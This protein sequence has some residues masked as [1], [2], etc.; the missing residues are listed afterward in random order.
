MYRTGFL[1]P[2]LQRL[3]TWSPVW[4]GAG[5]LLYFAP[6]FEPSW[7]WLLLPPLLLLASLVLAWRR[8]VPARGALF[9]LLMAAIG[10]AAAGLS[11]R[12]MPPM[13]DVPTRAVLAAGTVGAVDLMPD[14][15]RR[16]TLLRPVVALAMPR[17]G[18]A[19]AAMAAQEPGES[20][21]RLL[22][23]RL[24][25]DDQA[26]LLPGQRI[27]LRA[28]LHAPPAPDRPGGRDP[29]R[30]AFF[31][32]LG[33]SG[34][35]LGPVAPSAVPAAG[36]VP[37]L[38]AVAGASIG[39]DA[40]GAVAARGASGTGVEGGSR[41]A[42]R[43]DGAR[44]AASL[45]AIVPGGAGG[46]RGLR[47]RVAAR[48]LRVLPGVDGAIAATLLTGLGTAIPQA[49]RDAFAASGLAHILA[50]AGL[51]LAIVT[52]L[53]VGTIR[54][55]LSRF[56]WTALFLP[57]R[58]MA[59]IGGL[60]AGGFYMLMTGM[61]LPGIRALLMASVMVLALLT[62]R[63]ALSFRGLAV[64]A[65][66][67]LLW[68]PAV[69]L[70]VGFQMSFAAVLALISGYE[71]LRPA[72]RRLATEAHHGTPL[73]RATMHGMSLLTTS[74][75]AGL[76]SLPFAMFHF[77]R[78]QLYFVLANL[79]AVP[80]TA[81]WVMP[82]GL[83]SLLAMPVGAERLFLLPMGWGIE[84]VL[85]L[86]RAVSSLP[87][88]S[89]AV[90]GMPAP[91]LVV[92]SAGLIGLCLFRR[93]FW[94]LAS[95]LPL[96]SGL[97]SPWMARPPDLL[98]S[99]DARLIAL[100]ESGGGMVVNAM[101]GASAL[102]LESWKRFWAVTGRVGAI[103]DLAGAADIACDPAGCRIERRGRVVLLMLRRPGG[104]DDDGARAEDADD[105]RSAGAC[106][107]LSLLVAPVPA[108]D[109]CRGVPRIDRFT[110]WRQ[111][112]QAVWL[113]RD[114][115]EL[116][117]DRDFRGDR[118]WVAPVPSRG[119]RRPTLPLAMAE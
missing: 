102:V 6:R 94:R 49:D 19:P 95:I 38:S 32:G 75:F 25:D 85:W 22:R 50:V 117:D 67:M 18:G 37:G 55:L 45:P 51:H 60:G 59:A 92:L 77:G 57:C 106:Q 63:R 65:L 78:M 81:L 56:E 29:Q 66:V 35:A 44:A 14:G 79:L 109:A 30:E 47:E 89:L 24:R 7:P 84:I 114:G 103:P 33:G 83:L 93:P 36:F 4:V 52:G 39:A 21:R 71:A 101:P 68:H 23:V 107:G 53:A 97:C 1:A 48:I 100:R 8:S 96:V 88:A 112:S 31:S 110:V 9:C 58:E 104:D 5:I 118:P 3:L 40:G 115:I 73:R 105:E 116:R 86:A 119:G 76:A 69:L 43:G 13:P 74:V 80:I 61:H 64:A 90:P 16:V 26:A 11:T 113:S 46:M 10:F 62:G 108:G 111:G 87:A 70:E 27:V 28:L 42:G 20:W 2:D 91:G 98:V 41:S 54:F 82:A 15:S 72:M 34:R 17:R 12:R 99:G